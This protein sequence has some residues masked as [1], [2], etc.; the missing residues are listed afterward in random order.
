MILCGEEAEWLDAVTAETVSRP[1]CR[2]PYARS[3]EQEGPIPALHLF[4]AQVCHILIGR[5]V[6]FQAWAMASLPYSL[7]KN[8]FSIWK[9]VSP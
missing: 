8:E 9:D 2:P 7:T 5:N 6:W 3:R 4:Y 1:F